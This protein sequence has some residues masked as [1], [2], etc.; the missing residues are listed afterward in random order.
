MSQK[1]VKKISQKLVKNPYAFT[2]FCP[3]V[4]GF[5]PTNLESYTIVPSIG[6]SQLAQEKNVLKATKQSSLVSKV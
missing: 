4:A 6:T 2:H 1:L 3:R 5:K